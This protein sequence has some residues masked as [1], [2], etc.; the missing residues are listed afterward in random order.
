MTIL[1]YQYILY[2]GLDTITFFHFTLWSRSFKKINFPIRL[3]IKSLTKIPI[4]SRSSIRSKITLSAKKSTFFANDNQGCDRS[5][6]F[7]SQSRSRS[8]IKKGT[9]SLSRSQFY[10]KIAVA[11]AIF[12]AIAT[13]WRS[14]FQNSAVSKHPLKTPLWIYCA[15]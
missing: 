15:R 8:K 1:S 2:S 6:F 4:K 14:A 12:F 11:V 13:R 10:L 7:R 3:P 5:F 9:R